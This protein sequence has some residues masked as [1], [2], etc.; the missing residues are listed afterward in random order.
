MGHG[1]LLILMGWIPPL[2]GAALFESV[3]IKA[4]LAPWSRNTA[5][6]A[7][8]TNELARALLN[9]CDPFLIGF[10]LS[11]GLSGE[12]SWPRSAPH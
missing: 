7:R 9:F 4:D 12:I 8:E 6:R 3:G 11:I 1:E 2:A 10:F 5:G